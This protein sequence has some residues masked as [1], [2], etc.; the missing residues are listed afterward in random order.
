VDDPADADGRIGVR[1][2]DHDLGEPGSID[3]RGPVPN[4]L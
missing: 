4:K 3:I 2:A 1:E